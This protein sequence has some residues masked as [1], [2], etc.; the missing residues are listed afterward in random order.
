MMHKTRHNY[1]FLFI[2][3]YVS[4]PSHLLALKLRNDEQFSDIESIRS[5]DDEILTDPQQI[6]HE[7]A[8]F[9]K[10][11]YSSH[12]SFNEDKCKQ[13]L[14]SISLPHLSVN[15]AADLGA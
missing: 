1:Y 2:I 11:L 3:I 12:I 9:Y 14:N 15:A 5:N 10:N 6:N 4:R 7:F 13:F 8:A